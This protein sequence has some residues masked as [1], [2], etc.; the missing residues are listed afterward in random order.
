MVPHLRLRLL[1]A[2]ARASH[3]HLRLVSVILHLVVPLVTVKAGS[4]A[5]FPHLAKAMERGSRP[6]AAAVSFVA[7]SA[8]ALARFAFVPCR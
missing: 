6:V 1:P 5:A 3:F 2:R 4:P 8:P 7:G